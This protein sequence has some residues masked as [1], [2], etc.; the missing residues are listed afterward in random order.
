MLRD[1]A[2][3]RDPA[4]KEQLVRRYLPL[5]RS[6]AGRFL[7]HRVAFED[8]CQVAAIGLLKALDR[9]DPARGAAFSSYAVP[10]IA[11]ELQRHLRDHAWAVR[12][13]RSLIELAMSIRAAEADLSRELGRPARIGEIAGR[14]G[15]SVERAV[16]GLQA[17]DARDG[18][19]LDAPWSQADHTSTFGDSIGRHDAGFD[20]VDDAIT[21]DLLSAVLDERERQVLWLRFHTG[22]KQREIGEL[23]GCS[24]MHVSRLIRAALEKLSDA[25]AGV[26]EPRSHR[27]AE[28]DGLQALLG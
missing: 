28:P 3:T 14:L 17:A 8:L 7:S 26:G 21:I 4:I 25:A 20:R 24:Q 15:I 1:Y 5:A 9:Y 16:E 13:P 23:V 10:T 22:L 12:P 19:S 6:V 2:A 27:R 18:T 11:G